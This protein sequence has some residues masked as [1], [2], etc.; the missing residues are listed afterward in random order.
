MIRRALYLAT[1]PHRAVLGLALDLL[2]GPEQPLDYVSRTA[3]RTPPSVVV[4]VRLDGRDIARAV[5]HHRTSRE[6]RK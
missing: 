1:A 4:E 3:P 2:L 6:A 5:A